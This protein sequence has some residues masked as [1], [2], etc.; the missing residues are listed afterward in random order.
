MKTDRAY[1]V[2][3]GRFHVRPGGS[4]LPPN[5]NG[6]LERAHAG[7][8]TLL[9]LL[10]LL[11]LRLAGHRTLD[12]PI[13]TSKLHSDATCIPTLTSGSVTGPTHH[14][15]MRASPLLALDRNVCPRWTPIQIHVCGLPFFPQIE[16]LWLL[17]SPASWLS[18]WASQVHSS[19]LSPVACL[20]GSLLFCCANPTER[21]LLQLDPRRTST[22]VTFQSWMYDP[23]ARIIRSTL[24][25]SFGPFWLLSVTRRPSAAELYPKPHNHN[26]H[27]MPK[28]GNPL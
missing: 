18:S 24:Q 9:L 12:F 28:S 14:H 23:C 25:T 19:A 13:L 7:W 22:G 17:I 1:V 15:E 3:Y 8:S 27:R 4:P 11:R 2:R 26:L 10:L 20:I 16:W 5:L 21:H 6:V